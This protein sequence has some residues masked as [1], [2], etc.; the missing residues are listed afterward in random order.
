MKKL[1]DKALEAELKKKIRFI[2]IFENEG[3]KWKEIYGK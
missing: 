3:I 1:L 2:L